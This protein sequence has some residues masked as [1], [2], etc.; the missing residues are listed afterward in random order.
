MNY[1][2]RVG[3]DFKTVGLQRI[4]SING[5]TNAELARVIFA[6]VDEVTLISYD[7][8]IGTKRNKD[9]RQARQIVHY[10]L[11]KYTTFTLEDIGRQTKND[12]CTVLHS[13]K[14]VELD[15]SDRIYKL[16]VEEIDQLIKYKINN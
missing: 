5:K 15:C 6:S 10:F 14:V 4:K 2:S 9:I 3:I 8:I 1:I 16:M 12:H 13:V 7:K 11:K